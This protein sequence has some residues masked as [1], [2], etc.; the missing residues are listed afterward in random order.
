M[1]LRAYQTSAVDRLR[2]EYQQGRR[3]PVLCLPTGGGKTLVAAEIIRLAVAKGNRV[4]FAAGRVELM[5]QAISKLASAGIA[6]VRVIRADAPEGNASSPI[7]VASIPT[8]ASARWRESLPP[9]DLVVLD[10]CHH[11]KASTWS[12]I[13]DNYTSAKLLGL[14]ATPQRGDGRSLGDIFDSIVVGS[15]VKE[16]TDLGYLVSCQVFA[17]AR[18]LER[19]L[20]M[21]PIDAYR[22]YANKKPTLVFAQT[23]QH[24]RSIAATFIAD[25]IR[26]GVVFGDSQD[27]EETLAAFAAGELDALVGVSVFV[28]GWDAPRSQAAIFARKFTHVGWYLQAIGR[29]LRPHD[30]KRHATVV[31][32]CGSALVHGTPDIDREYTLDGKGITS[33]DRTPMRQCQSCGGVFTERARCPYCDFALPALERRDPKVTG[34]GVTAMPEKTPPRPWVVAI[35]AKFRSICPTCTA[36]IKVGDSVVWAKGQKARHEECARRSAR[37]ARGKSA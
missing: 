37:G 9:A 18:L 26:T 8:L 7:V 10:E 31:D 36:A 33:P 4:L 3:A 19:E 12:Q 30:G 28:E 20:A 29:V 35:K 2:L 15:S 32:L 1:K 34:E 13:A 14:T 5:N 16:L 27:R 24:A 23:K 21:A 6:D 17:P 11:A 22:L 25:G